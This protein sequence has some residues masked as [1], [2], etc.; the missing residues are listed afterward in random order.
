MAS[1]P[2]P[3]KSRGAGGPPPRAFFSR[4]RAG[5]GSRLARAGLRQ[6]T[7]ARKMASA[8]SFPPPAL[9][10]CG[11]M[12][13]RAGTGETLLSPT[14]PP[15]TRDSPGRRPGGGGGPSHAAPRRYVR[16]TG[17]ASRARRGGRL[18]RGRGRGGGR[19]APKPR[20]PAA[21]EPDSAEGGGAGKQEEELR[22]AGAGPCPP[23]SPISPQLTS[24]QVSITE[25]QRR[26][27]CEIYI[28]LAHPTAYRTA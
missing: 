26:A 9:D 1:R 22:G 25:S 2:R 16:G 23:T 11:R 12:R 14:S 20:P 5:S 13:L 21:R 8:S 6:E 28:Q 7:R 19:A 3:P 10:S 15:R 24:P 4:A 18:R 17:C 27:L